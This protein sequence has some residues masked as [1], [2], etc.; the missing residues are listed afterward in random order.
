MKMLEKDYL[1][2]F[3]EYEVENDKGE[4]VKEKRYKAL[5]TRFLTKAMSL[6][7]TKVAKNWSRFD[8]FHDVLYTFALADICDVEPAEKS[9]DEK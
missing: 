3:E 1:F 9:E 7:N 8:Q 2:E 5:C 6:L 4:K